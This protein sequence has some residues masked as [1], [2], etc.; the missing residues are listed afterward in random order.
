MLSDYQRQFVGMG[1]TLGIIFLT[2]LVIQRFIPSLLW[3]SIIAIATYPMYL[4][5][6]T[7]FGNHHNTAAFI[8][9]CLFSL[10][11]IIPL[12]Y[13][14]TILVK[15]FQVLVTYLQLINREGGP[16]PSFLHELPWGGAELESYWNQ[17][18]R[19]PGS[20]RF[21]LSNVPVSI[22]P[23]SYYLKQIG[24][25][26]AHRGFQLGFTVLTLFFFYR[27]GDHIINQVNQIGEYCLGRRWSRYSER[28][29]I[30]LRATVNG[31]VMVGLG[32][33]ILM[34]ICYALVGL[35]APT[36]LGFITAFAAMIPLIAPIV[37]LLLALVL[38]FGSHFILAL[39]LIVC[40]GL[41]L[42]TADHFIK[43]ALIG[44]AIQLPFLAVL[45]GILGGVETLG[46]LGLFVG[47]VIMV[48]FI[49]LWYELQGQQM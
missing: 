31:T 40:G 41:I 25:G 33:G 5:F 7:F 24:F 3:A 23:A 42:F 39:L 27:D 28:L 38:V 45:F 20:L 13:L 14:V 15:E 30:A 4:R 48:F 35:P 22:T 21:I 11:I 32:V 12:S 2:L 16:A 29:P 37:L 36:L 44:G 47:P 19:A 9:T 18:I 26:I 49:T 34:G 1:L 10:V 17:Y 46:F 6:R 8:F 43:P